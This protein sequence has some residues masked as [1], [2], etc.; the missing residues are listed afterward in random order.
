MKKFLL[1]FLMAGTCIALHAQPTL[2]ASTGNPVAGEIYYGRYVDTTGIDTGAS[3]A[4]V[5]WN[6]AS[7]I[8]NDSDTTTYMTCASTA[9]C[10]SFPGSNLVMYDGYDY[11]YGVTSTS[12]YQFIGVVSDTLQHLPN[13]MDVM[14]YPLTYHTTHQDTTTVTFSDMGI[15]V[16]VTVTD[17][18]LCDAYGTLILPTDTFTNALRVHTI[19]IVKDS[20]NVLGIPQVQETRTDRYSWYAPG[21]HNQIMYV[22]YDTVSTSPAPFISEAKYFWHVTPPPATAVNGM[23]ANEQGLKLYPNPASNAINAVFNLT[24]NSSEIVITDQV[25]QVVKNVSTSDLKAGRNELSIPVADMPDGMYILQLRTAG[26]VTSQKISV[27]K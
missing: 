12:G 7:L 18:S 25:G 26:G 16:Y 23:P 2:N 5:T 27:R 6:F 13:P 3:G 20:V 19:E 11:F 24:D 9:Y 1:S 21:F 17:N 8:T 14:Y 22:N 10:D 15:T 4:G